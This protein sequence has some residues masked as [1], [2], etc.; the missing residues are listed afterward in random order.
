MTTNLS[1]PALAY[2]VSRYPAVSHT[3]ILR[4]IQHLRALGHTNS[5]GATASSI[6][7]VMRSVSNGVAIL[8]GGTD[9]RREGVVL[10]DTFQP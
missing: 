3:F 7:T 9:P 5:T 4:E 8:T 10:G 2:L 1:S 6:N